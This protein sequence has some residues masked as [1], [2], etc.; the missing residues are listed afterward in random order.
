MLLIAGIMFAWLL[1]GGFSSTKIKLDG[2]V[3]ILD[4]LNFDEALNK[5]DQL[6]V[7]FYAPWYV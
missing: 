5:H 4:D 1:V 3:L 2:D 7:E 6:L